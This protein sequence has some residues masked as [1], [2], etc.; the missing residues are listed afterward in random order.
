M[1]GRPEAALAGPREQMIM[2]ALPTC[3][4]GNL[5]PSSA[6]Y[7]SPAGQGEPTPV[8]PI[9][10]LSLLPRAPTRLK[11]QW[12]QLAMLRRV[13]SVLLG[14]LVGG[15]QPIVVGPGL[16]AVCVLLYINL[17][18]YLSIYLLVCNDPR[19]SKQTDYDPAV[20]ATTRGENDTVS[21]DMDDVDDTEDVDDDGDDDDSDD[22]DTATTATTTATPRRRLRRGRR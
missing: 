16:P 1:T 19:F 14:G 10:L 7:P 2:S 4:P 17:S 5:A 12:Q 15:C 6:D 22:G 21:D 8:G 11:R 3:S 18:I 9:E 20:Q 13:A